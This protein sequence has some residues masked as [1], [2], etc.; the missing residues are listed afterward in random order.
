MIEKNVWKSNDDVLFDCVGLIVWLV[1]I[2]KNDDKK[3]L[4]NENQLYGVGKR[5]VK[6]NW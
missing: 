4:L 5:I 6:T 2:V 3:K 1:L